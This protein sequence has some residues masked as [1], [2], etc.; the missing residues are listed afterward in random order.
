M[1]VAQKVKT[2]LQLRREQDLCRREDIQVPEEDESKMNL[3]R[4]VQMTL[5]GV[6]LQNF[7]AS[8]PLLYLFQGNAILNDLLHL[9][10][11]DGFGVKERI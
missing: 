2:A 1:D 5:V 4:Y 6:G 10:T 7:R 8:P 9:P 3:L 11:T